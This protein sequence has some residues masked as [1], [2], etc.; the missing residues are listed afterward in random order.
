MIMVAILVPN[1]QQDTPKANGLSDFTFPD[2]ST[3]RTI[4][5]VFGTSYLAGNCI[6]FG[7][8]AHTGIYS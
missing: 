5:I 7:E 8:L 1:I 2:N 6:Y 4:P 3:N